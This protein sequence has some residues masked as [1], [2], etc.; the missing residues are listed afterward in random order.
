M[1]RP[2][3][4]ACPGPCLLSSR[5]RH[6][7]RCLHLGGSSKCNLSPLPHLPAQHASSQATKADTD[8]IP[9]RPRSHRVLF[10]YSVHPSQSAPLLPTSPDTSLAPASITSH[11]QSCDPAIPPSEATLAALLPTERPRLRLPISVKR[12]LTLLAVV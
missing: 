5:P 3:K 6:P 8:A 9:S 1:L 4:S 12:K 11:L 10:W 2:L 7:T